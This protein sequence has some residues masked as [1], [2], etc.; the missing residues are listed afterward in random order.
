MWMKTEAVD[1]T[2]LAKRWAAF[3]RS[4]LPHWRK[5]AN[6]SADS[7]VPSELDGEA[8]LSAMKHQELVTTNGLVQRW[9]A[10]GLERW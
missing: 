2:R 7:D 1:H 9:L 5:T 4:R 8:P 6:E 10:P 3:L